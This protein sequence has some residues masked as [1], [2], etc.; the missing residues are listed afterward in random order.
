MEAVA[1]RCVPL[2]EVWARDGLASVTVASLED[3][4]FHP[5]LECDPRGWMHYYSWP[6]GSQRPVTIWIPE[7]EHADALDYMSRATELPWEDGDDVDWFVAAVSHGRRWIYLGWLF[8]LVF[9]APAVLAGL[10][11][12]LVLDERDGDDD[13]PEARTSFSPR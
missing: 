13:G 10:G 1:E 7:S 2:T 5:V 8:N 12:A 6:L 3:A 9:G 4:G 11:L